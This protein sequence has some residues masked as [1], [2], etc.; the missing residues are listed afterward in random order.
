MSSSLTSNFILLH[1]YMFTCM[2]LII[3]YHVSLINNNVPSEERLYERDGINNKGL[4][5]VLG[6]G[7]R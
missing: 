4:G 6:T 7:H 5:P 2:S 3:T 1:L